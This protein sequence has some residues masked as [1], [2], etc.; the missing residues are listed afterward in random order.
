MRFLIVALFC[1]PGFGQGDQPTRREIETAYRSKYGE[2]GILFT[3]WERRRIQEV[4]GWALKFKRVAEE[5]PLG[6][7]LLRYQAVARKGGTCAEYRIS[8]TIPVA[9]NVQIKPAVNVEPEGV[10]ACR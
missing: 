8:Q 1:A 10:K 6:L 3:R 9:G 4:R 5:H 2:G 7:L